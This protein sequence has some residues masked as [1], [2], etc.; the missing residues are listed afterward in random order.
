MSY[1]IEPSQEISHRADFS[2]L[3]NARG[4]IEAVEVGT[5]QGEFATEFLSRW[6]GHRLF[7]V[8]DYEPYTERP[9][10]R[11]G[12]M[13]I[14]TVSLMRDPQNYGRFR[15]VQGKS[16]DIA[17]LIPE[18]MPWMKPGFIYIDAD[19][20]YENVRD[21]IEAWW[22]LLVRGGIFAGHDY[23]DEHP[24][25]M[26]AVQEFA[27]A[28][29]LVVRLTHDRMCVSWYIYKGGEPDSLIRKLWTDGAIPNPRAASGG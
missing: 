26:R 29:D 21:D 20:K 8:D 9:W 7:L 11:L 6:K 18:T 14:A 27:Q 1:L 10:G 25:V 15:F 24:G 13:L 2:L 12:D 23:D 19:H 22:P 5:D 3:C 17:R 16:T 28:H 4:I